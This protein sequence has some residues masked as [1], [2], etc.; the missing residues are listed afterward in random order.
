MTAA[1]LPFGF[2]NFCRLYAIAT[3]MLRFKD[4]GSTHCGF[5]LDHFP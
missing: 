3:Q 5:W 2:T 1:T 4:S